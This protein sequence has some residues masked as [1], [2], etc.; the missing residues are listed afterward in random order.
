MRGYRFEENDGAR[1]KQLPRWGSS[2]PRPMASA[3]LHGPLLLVS[4]CNAAPLAINKKGYPSKRNGNA[5]RR[6]MAR[7][8]FLPLRN[9]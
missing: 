7:L 4:I 2:R 1:A 3:M 9:S 5:A 8:P 6:K